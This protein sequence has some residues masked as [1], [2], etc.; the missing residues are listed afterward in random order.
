M[1]QE[2]TR[3]RGK[4]SSPG[5]Q[6]LP[7]PSGR[8]AFRSCLWIK[9]SAHSFLFNGACKSH[10]VHSPRTDGSQQWA[11]LVVPG[12]LTENKQSVRF[13][14]WGQQAFWTYRKQ[15]QWSLNNLYTTLSYLTL[16]WKKL[17]WVPAPRISPTY[18]YVL[19][20]PYVEIILFRGSIGR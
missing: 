3:W 7:H 15:D 11:T 17:S 9:S 5:P 12:K 6:S 16:I 2:G 20:L 14:P 13:H 19:K 4:M 18:N 10:T 1:E 8:L